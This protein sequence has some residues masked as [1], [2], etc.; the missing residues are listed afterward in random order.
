MIWGILTAGARNADSWPSMLR[1]NM[2]VMAA[3]K[4]ITKSLRASSGPVS[5]RERMQR[6]QQMH[7]G[8]NA[9]KMFS[10]LKEGMCRLST[11]N[12]IPAKANWDEMVVPFQYLPMLG[13]PLTGRPVEDVPCLPLP[14]VQEMCSCAAALRNSSCTHEAAVDASGYLTKF[15][16]ID[17]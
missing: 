17:R 11:V 6:V 12:L 13:R 15:G 16:E 3:V 5:L 1:L 14:F 8:L 4:S 10:E 2:I 9:M 7:E